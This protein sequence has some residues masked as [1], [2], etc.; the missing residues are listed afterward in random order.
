MTVNP[1]KTAADMVYNVLKGGNLSDELEKMR[2][3]GGMNELDVRFASEIAGGV[4]R[5]LE[6][7]DCAVSDASNVKINKIAPYVLSVIRC[8]AYQILFMDKV[9]ESAA[10][11]ESVKLIR[12]SGNTR[13]CGFVNAVLRTVAKNKM[14]FS[15]PTDRI[16]NLSVRYSCPK[17]I[18]Q[19]FCDSL[20]DEAELLLRA[21]GEKP[22]TFIRANKLKTT[23]DELTALLKSHGWECERYFSD[24]FAPLDTLITASK[25]EGLT[26]IDEFK[27]GDV[28][29][30]GCRGIIRR[31]RSFA[32]GGRYRYRYV[33][34]S[35]RKD[36][37]YFRAYE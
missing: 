29:C 33:R 17:W 32:G 23:A 15:L 8:G 36:N 18:T 34:R 24:L 11:N 21:M 37:A 26:Q 4:L 35:R 14:S 13:L 20:G 3:K 1:R 28:L 7:I 12:K 6:L 5:K 30:P 2:A 9:P 19:I 10:V 22:L 25:I 16:E 27:K 31:V